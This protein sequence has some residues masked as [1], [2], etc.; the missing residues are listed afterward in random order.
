MK[1]KVIAFRV[2]EDEYAALYYMA[3][4]KN[5]KLAEHVSESLTSAIMQGFDA[6]T[7]ERK[8]L[9]AK[10]KREAKKAAANGAQ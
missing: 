9:E 4:T 5:I 8:R 7:K 1:T 10:A 6:L 2:T 3:R